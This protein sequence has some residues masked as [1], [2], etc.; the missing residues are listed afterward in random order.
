MRGPTVCV[1]VCACSCHCAA[2]DRLVAGVSA[3]FLVGTPVLAGGVPTVFLRQ[4]CPSPSRF[5]LQSN[6]QPTRPFP[7]SSPGHPGLVG[8]AVAGPGFASQCQCVTG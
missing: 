7:A 8:R 4:K 5:R 2:R 3:V 1:C 6:F